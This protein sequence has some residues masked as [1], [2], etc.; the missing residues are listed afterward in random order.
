[1]V[2][3]ANNRD[4]AQVSWEQRVMEGEPRHVGIGDRL[5]DDRAVGAQGLV[6][7]RTDRVGRIDAQPFQPQHLGIAGVGEVGQIL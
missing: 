4:L 1:M 7:R 6:P 3:V 5:I 2:L